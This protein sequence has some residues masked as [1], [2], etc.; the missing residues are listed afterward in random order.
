MLILFS[1]QHDFDILTFRLTLLWIGKEWTKN[2]SAAN[3]ATK[4]PFWESS[5][6][7]LWQGNAQLKI[8]ISFLKNQYLR[9]PEL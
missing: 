8:R 4:W 5:P 3:P 7:P 6:A 2:G 1:G 9:K